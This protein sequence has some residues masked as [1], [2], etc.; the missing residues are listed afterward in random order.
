[1]SDDEMFQKSREV[2]VY[3]RVS[4]IHKLRIVEAIK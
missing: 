2:S 3:A 4:P 1:M